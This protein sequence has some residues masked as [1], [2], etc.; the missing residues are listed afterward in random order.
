M[1]NYP[2]TNEELDFSEGERQIVDPATVIIVPD[3]IMRAVKL[4]KL[5]VIDIQNYDLISKVCSSDDLALWVAINQLSYKNVQFSNN[6]FMMFSQ[7]NTSFSYTQTRTVEP[8]SHT[9]EVKT[10]SKQY[11]YTVKDEE[12]PFYE[13]KSIG[14]TILVVVQPG[15]LYRLEKSDTV[16]LDFI[17]EL[18][19]ATE[20]ATNPS[21]AADSGIF[22]TFL[23]LTT[24]TVS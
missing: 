18:I 7:A 2:D 3:F 23:K 9:E 11:M 21:M 1:F 14:R 22:K 4:H 12:T 8:L 15:F 17:R 19:K 6:L 16:A 10:A 20:T 5:N 24:S 13:L